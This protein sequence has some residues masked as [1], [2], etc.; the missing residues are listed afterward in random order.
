MEHASQDGSET[1]KGDRRQNDR[2]KV[3]LP[4]EGVDRRTGQRRSGADRRQ[5]DRLA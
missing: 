4:V 3:D 1:P 2:R 5:V